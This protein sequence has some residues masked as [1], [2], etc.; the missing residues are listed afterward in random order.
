MREGVQMFR[1]RYSSP[2]MWGSG[3]SSS[4]G[5][6]IAALAGGR[7]VLGRVAVARPRRRRRRRLLAQR[8]DRGGSVRDAE[9]GLDAV[10]LGSPHVTFTG[11]DHG[12]H[13]VPLA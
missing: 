7:P 4:Y 2:S 8:T 3:S 10:V 12:S 6:A 1:L 11:D 9:V 5:E 13:R